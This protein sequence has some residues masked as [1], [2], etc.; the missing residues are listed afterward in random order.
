MRLLLRFWAV[1]VF[2]GVL[3]LASV[4]AVVANARDAQAIAESQRHAR[5]ITREISGLMVQTQQYAQQQSERARQQWWIR[6]Q[7]IAA[8]LLAAK[9]DDPVLQGRQANLQTQLDLLARLFPL[10]ADKSPVDSA[11][12]GQERREL[13]VD[14]LLTEVL[15][16]SEEAH[17]WAEIGAQRREASALKVRLL[18]LGLAVLLA[19]MTVLIAVVLARRVFAPLRTLQAAAQALGKG[20]PYPNFQLEGGAEFV[21]V[22]RA[23][24]AMREAMAQREADLKQ[25]AE[26]L[27]ASNQELR[28]FAYVASHDLQ[29]PLRSIVGFLHLATER[30][31]AVADE[32]SSDW[33]SRASAS[34]LRMQALMQ[35]L[36]SYA[37]FENKQS[38]RAVVDLNQVVKDVLELM[39]ASISEC[40]GQIEAG[41]L[42]VV[43]GD[44]AQL[45][46]LFL[47]LIG[48]AIKYRGAAAPHV[49]VT[50]MDQGDQY[51]ISISDNGIGIAHD[52]RDKVFELFTRLHSVHEYPGTG[53]GLAICRRVVREHGGRIWVEAQPGSG[54][55][56]SFTFPKEGSPHA[57][58]DTSQHQ[59]AV[60]GGG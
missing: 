19:A 57:H 49:L 41:V 30:L 8:E 5:V 47:N 13:L 33:L 45:E 21:E 12:I 2:T 23:F 52:Q 44:P 11:A 16:M 28:R 15:S 39:N 29:S 58:T 1:A 14:H 27:T 51:L 56:L 6:H 50:S 18:T 54:T 53:L 43:K 24:N 48:N 34:A 32:K 55:T 59:S 10:L 26:A 20:E 38:R 37:Q 35:D 46:Q 4:I 7:R 9:E 40:G 31:G 17:R 42:P 60:S 22:G 36:L 3:A 25:H